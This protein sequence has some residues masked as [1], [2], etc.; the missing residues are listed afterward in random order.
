M[1]RGTRHDR[2]IT[3]Y[4]DNIYYHYTKV[5]REVNVMPYKVKGKIVYNKETGKKVGTTKGSVANYLAAL[6][7][8]ADKK[9]KKK[10]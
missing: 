9:G 8:N 2:Y 3:A 10:K 7:A 1:I 4:R 6:Y 5:D